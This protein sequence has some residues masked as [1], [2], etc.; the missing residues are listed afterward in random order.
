MKINNKQI[1]G[2][3][4]IT[5][6]VIIFICNVTLIVMLAIPPMYIFIM[7]FVGLILICLSTKEE[8]KEVSYP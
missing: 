4:L 5:M 8:Q 6:S 7:F 2:I 3:F 1:L